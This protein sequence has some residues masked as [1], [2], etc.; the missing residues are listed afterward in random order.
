MEAAK[1]ILATVLAALL[2]FQGSIAA[3]SLVE[4]SQAKSVL[5]SSDGPEVYTSAPSLEE[6]VR[7]SSWD[8]AMIAERFTYDSQAGNV[9]TESLKSEFKKTE[10]AFNANAKAIEK[11]IETKERELEALPQNATEPASP[12]P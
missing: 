2:S 1:K 9:K 10:A 4:E 7:L 12:R 11:R 5:G 6:V 3:G 8:I